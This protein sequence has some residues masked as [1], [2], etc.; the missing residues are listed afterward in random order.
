MRFH[1][2]GLRIEMVIPHIVQQHGP[3]HHLPGMAHKIFQQPKFTRLKLYLLAA[4]F[5]HMFH[6][7]KFKVGNLEIGIYRRAARPA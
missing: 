5:D 6:D 1:H 3:R 2:I 4:A 7:I